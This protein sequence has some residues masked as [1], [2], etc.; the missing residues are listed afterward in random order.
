MYSHIILAADGSA[1]S[2]R[3]AEHAAALADASR[4]CSVA[5]IFVP[6]MD[7]SKRSL[8]QQER[9]TVVQW[10]RREKLARH[11]ALFEEKGIPYSVLIREGE[12]GPAIVKYANAQSA[13]LVILGSRGLN[14][15]QQFVLGSVSHKVMKRVTCPVMIVK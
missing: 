11:E 5:I 8:L 3:A 7:E 6:R 10:E 9:M 15:L 4:P 2:Y 14:H 12:P 1:H 13:D